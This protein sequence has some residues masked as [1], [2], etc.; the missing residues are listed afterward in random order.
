M[1][2]TFL[3]VIVIILLFGFTAAS[4]EEVS[5]STLARGHNA[6][7]IEYGFEAVIYDDDSFSSLW[8][9]IAKG[10]TPLP[11]EPGVDF[12]SEMV[13]A[14]TPGPQPTGGYDV[15]IVDIEDK[16]EVLRVIVTF[17]VPGPEDFVTEAIT[18]P[19][20]IVSTERRE[21]PVEFVWE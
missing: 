20:H 17:R 4:A 15:E 8:G 1:R 14:V 16:G 5:F 3:S 21:V 11:P 18:Q 7:G 6:S 12:E 19:Y 9:D 10:I 2:K 13:I